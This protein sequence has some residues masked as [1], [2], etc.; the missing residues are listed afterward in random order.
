MELDTA[1]N[2]EQV[3]AEE[4]KK[5]EPL[6]TKLQCPWSEFRKSR[7]FASIDADGILRANM[8]D[9]LVLIM[10]RGKWPRMLAAIT[11]GMIED[12][13][14]QAE[15]DYNGV[16]MYTIFILPPCDG[17]VFKTTC[18]GVIVL[19]APMMMPLINLAR[20]QQ[21]KLAASK[22]SLLFVPWNRVLKYF[23]REIM[24]G[25]FGLE[26]WIHLS[27][28]Q[29]LR[30]H[31]I[32]SKEEKNYR[33]YSK[34]SVDGELKAY[35]T[36]ANEERSIINLMEY[37]KY[38]Y[39]DWHT[40]WVA[41]ICCIRLSLQKVSLIMCVNYCLKCVTFIMCVISKISVICV[42]ELICFIH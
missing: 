11:I 28:L 2:P 35:G 31:M 38:K 32:S 39:F 3:Q 36:C 7:I 21:Q 23:C 14:E 17:I 26:D 40:C 6:L 8:H 29:H 10:H 18:V 33:L 1:G 41:H 16:L 42:C 27:E 37:I 9:A 5:V 12:A 34:A 30:N 15:E 4:M 13:V 24:G 22:K 20:L 19:C 25:K